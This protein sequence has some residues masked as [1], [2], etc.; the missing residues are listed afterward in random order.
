MW[1]SEKWYFSV[2]QERH[3]DFMGGSNNVT[4]TLSNAATVGAH[5]RDQASRFSAEWRFVENARLT[6]DV[7]RMKWAESGQAPGVRFNSYQHTNWAVGWD[8]GFGGPWR[9]AAQY[10]RAGEGNCTLT[11]GLDCSATGLSSYMITAGTRYRF[12]RQTFV[13]A[14]VAKLQNGASARYD[15]WASSDPARGADILQAAVGLSYTF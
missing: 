2:H 3:N 8:Q 14:I 4:G 13:Y 6:L 7:A 10:I 5:S 11:G 9:F 1:D 15:N 12:D